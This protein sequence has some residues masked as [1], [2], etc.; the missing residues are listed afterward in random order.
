MHLHSSF[1]LCFTNQVQILSILVP[2]EFL[3]NVCDRLLLTVVSS[4]KPTAVE[5]GEV[6]ILKLALIMGASYEM[7]VIQGSIYL[8]YG[9]LPLS[10]WNSIKFLMK[11]HRSRKAQQLGQEPLEPTF[12]RML[13]CHDGNSCVSVRQNDPRQKLL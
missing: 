4:T 11:T 8:F 3:L 10:L 13:T 2:N 1:L 5:H 9:Y 6:N 7:R 12:L